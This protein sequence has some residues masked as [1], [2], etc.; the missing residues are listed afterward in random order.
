MEETTALLVARLN[1]GENRE[2]DFAD[3][4]RR[5]HDRVYRWFPRIVAPAVR[6]ELTPIPFT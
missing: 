2:R 1:A 4:F 6:S 3:L 5:Y